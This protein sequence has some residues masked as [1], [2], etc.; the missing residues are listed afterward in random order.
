VAVLVV[1][2]PAAV[3]P[4]EVDYPVAVTESLAVAAVPVQQRNLQMD[5]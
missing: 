4:V 5:C 2:V 1:A 3:C